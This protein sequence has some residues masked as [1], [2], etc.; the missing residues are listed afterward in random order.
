[1]TRN[2]RRHPKQIC[3]MEVPV[4]SV[5]PELR[6]NEHRKKYFFHFYAEMQFL[7]FFVSLCKKLGG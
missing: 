2:L 4:T 1:L 3:Y 5:E 7:L 6:K